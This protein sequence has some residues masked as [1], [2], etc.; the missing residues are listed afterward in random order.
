VP[1]EVITAIIGVE[2]RYGKIQGS[3]RVIDSLLTLGFD[4]PRR[5]KF[6]RKELVNFFLLT[7]ENEL[8]ILDIKAHMLGQ[9][10]MVNL[11]LQA[12]ELT[13]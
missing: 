1:K 12:I 4:Y 10:V 3:Y 13:Q 2:T 11:Y 5:S 9:W 7:R 6:F 8:D